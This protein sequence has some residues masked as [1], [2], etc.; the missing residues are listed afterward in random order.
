MTPR[1]LYNIYQRLLAPA[2][3]A[4]PDAPDTSDSLH[5]IRQ[6]A[7]QG[8][9]QA[10]YNLGCLYASGENLPRDTEQACYWYT[11][12]AQQGYADAQYNLGCLYASGEEATRNTGQARYWFTQ[13]ARQNSADAQQALLE[14][15]ENPISPDN[16]PP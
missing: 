8:H 11:Q 15:F 9:A 5:A 12:A 7:Q 2:A 14:L 6:A 1:R 10:Q 4:M 13:A 16:T 3:C